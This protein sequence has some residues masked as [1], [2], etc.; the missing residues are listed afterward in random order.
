MSR[1]AKDLLAAVLAPLIGAAVGGFLGLV[2][3]CEAVRLYFR[4][5]VA[6]AVL[7]VVAMVWLP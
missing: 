3:T 2:V 6:V 1:I 5:L 7:G 4:P